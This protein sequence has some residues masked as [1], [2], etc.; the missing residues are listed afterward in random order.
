MGQLRPSSWGGGSSSSVHSK[1]SLTPIAKE[2]DLS[3]EQECIPSHFFGEIPV[4]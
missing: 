3:F 4:N 2:M 1:S